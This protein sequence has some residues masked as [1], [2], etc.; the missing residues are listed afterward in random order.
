M[1]LRELNINPA[2]DIVSLV[3]EGYNAKVEKSYEKVLTEHDM[4]EV[5]VGLHEHNIRGPHLEPFGFV[6][7]SVPTGNLVV[8]TVVGRYSGT[9][10][11]VHEGLMKNIAERL[12]ETY[13]VA[14]IHGL[15]PDHVPEKKD[16]W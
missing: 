12:S 16:R 2:I 14:Y 13:D 3:V 11:P 8:K 5:R 9:L 15:T 4:L 10:Q 1:T 6:T 7:M